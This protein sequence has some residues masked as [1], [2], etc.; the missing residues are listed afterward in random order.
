AHMSVD[1]PTIAF[2]V[3]AI[4]LVGSS[5]A[6][7]LLRNIVRAALSLILVFGAAAGVYVLLNAEFIAIVQV[8]IYAGAI[9][10]LILFA[11]MLTQHS[12]SQRSNPFSGQW[13]LA[14]LICV[15]LGAGIIYAVGSSTMLAGSASSTLP[16]AGVGPSTGTVVRLGQLLYSPFTYS[17]VLPFEIASIV[18]LVAIIGA[19]M[20][21]RAEEE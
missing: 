14:G 6:V 21:G 19:I 5:L 10:V 1:I 20:I 2:Y 18:L 9:T 12:M 15:L 3:I 7:V 4:A 17:Y 16:L 8:L 11:I 13:W